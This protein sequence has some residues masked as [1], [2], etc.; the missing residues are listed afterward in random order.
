[1]AHS[2]L[3]CVSDPRRG[4][5]QASSSTSWR[6]LAQGPGARAEGGAVDQRRVNL[7]GR[8]RFHAVCGNGPSET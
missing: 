6:P 7:A 8:L 5:G 4:P 3:M 2:W 1:M